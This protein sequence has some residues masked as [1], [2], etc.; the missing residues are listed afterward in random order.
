MVFREL[1][2]ELLE[3]LLLMDHVVIATGGGAV[4]HKKEWEQLRKNS[5]VVWLKADI[6]TIR[7]RLRIDPVSHEQRPP[8]SGDIEHEEVESILAER[9]Q[10]YMEG[11]DMAIDTSDKSPGE[12]AA[13]IKEYIIQTEKA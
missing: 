6:H 7:E 12:I 4:L 8:L 3:R 10:S 13:L 9:E 11:S 2:Q 5:L 1:E